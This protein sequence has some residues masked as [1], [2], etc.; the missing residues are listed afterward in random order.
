V[1]RRLLAALF[2][3]VV[4][5]VASMVWAQPATAAPPQC[6]V[7]EWQNPS[8]WHGCGDRAK[9]QI[10]ETLGCVGAPTP[11][12]PTAG[13]PGNFTDRPE[14]SMRS[15]VSGR[16]SSYGVG[17]YGLD[18]YNMGCLGTLANP[19]LVFWSN[20]AETEFMIAASIM[21][22]AHGLR[23]RAYDPGEM[24]GWSDGF[25]ETSTHSIFNNVFGRIGALTIVAIGLFFLW[26]AQKGDMGEAMKM[27]LWA[28]VV[29]AAATALFSW[30]T[31]SVHAV[32][33]I[34]V[35]SIDLA[36]KVVGQGPQSWDGP[37]CRLSPGSCVDH[38]T[39]AVRSTDT[40]V[41]AVLYRSW[42]RAV[43]GAAD[44]PTALTYGP[45]LY[46]ATTMQWN[47][48]ARVAGNPALRE[49][50]IDQKAQTFNAIAEK[51]RTEDPEAYEHLQ[52][53]H[54]SARFGNG[55]M[56]VGSAL[57]FAVFDMTASAIILFGF[58][59]I[60][61]GVPLFPLLATFGM[62]WYASKPLR[63]VANMVVAALFNIALFG[64]G[65]AAY[66]AIAS[67]VFQSSMP[68]WVQNLIVGLTGAAA[69]LL[70]RPIRHLTSTATGRS[71]GEPGFLARQ[72]NAGKE[73]Y[74]NQQA[75]TAAAG[76]AA[77]GGGAAQVR[78]ESAPA[79]PP[80]SNTRILAEAV[81]PTVATAAGHP[82]VAAAIKV[83]TGLRN[84]AGRAES[85]PPPASPTSPAPAPAPTSPAPA[86]AA[87]GRPES[88]S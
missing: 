7:A 38:R 61:L 21:G 54:G 11:G 15:G 85:T 41:D 28:I 88:R 75:A 47:E 25:I 49:S 14:S 48:A 6:T 87:A 32:D 64:F 83:A 17:G 66:L 70:L 1:T 45:A 26:R 39:A 71:R 58:G 56:A 67:T 9:A 13:L 2:A 33:K 79:Q 22:A 86:M 23:E 62:F 52:G 78:P 27:S 36:H 81:A 3:V 29:M 46:D 19:D 63:R 82:H 84:R 77:D 42:L 43:L 72:I 73:M 50:L 76:N 10:G 55:L 68:P 59:L 5:A 24:W 51:I 8:Q 16:Y 53:L 69:W 34:G 57:I 65:S 60:R 44:S 18:T 4:A 12:S 37:E 40:A 35:G 30:P 74:Q 20:A 80:R 31:Q